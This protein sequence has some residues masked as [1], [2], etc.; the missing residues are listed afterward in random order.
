MFL[1]HLDF[2]YFFSYIHNFVL[3]VALSDPPRYKHQT[4]N[5]GRF[6]LNEEDKS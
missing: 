1:T 6:S 4:E 2:T 5:T 3:E